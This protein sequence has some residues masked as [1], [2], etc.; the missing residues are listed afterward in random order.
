MH[1]TLHH[2][3]LFVA[4][5][6]AEDPLIRVFALQLQLAGEGKAGAQSTTAEPLA[7]IGGQDSWFFTRWKVNPFHARLDAIWS[8][9]PR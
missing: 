1:K 5:V 4:L 2:G 7:E 6:D 8:L 9:G 3:E